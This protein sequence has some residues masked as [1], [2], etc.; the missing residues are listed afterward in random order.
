MDIP[1][2]SCNVLFSRNGKSG[3]AFLGD[4]RSEEVFLAE[5]GWVVRD[6][7]FDEG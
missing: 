2:V 4:V 5:S 6:V 3:D 7:S 1:D